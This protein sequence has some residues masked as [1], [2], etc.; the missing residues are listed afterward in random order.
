M[1]MEHRQEKTEA[2]GKTSIAPILSTVNP[3]RTAES[4]SFNDD[5]QKFLEVYSSLRGNSHSISIELKNSFTF[6]RQP[7]TDTHLS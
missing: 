1:N 7:A 3:I 2:I 4:K 6:L 5:F